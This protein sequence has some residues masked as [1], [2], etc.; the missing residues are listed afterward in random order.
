MLRSFPSTEVSSSPKPAISLWVRCAIAVLTVVAGS[1][2]VRAQDSDRT[3][4][5]VNLSEAAGADAATAKARVLLRTVNGLRPTDTG[6]LTR[7][8][9]SA[10]PEGGPDAPALAEARAG[11]EA[12]EAAFGEFRS[13][14]AKKELDKARRILFAIAPSPATTKLLADLSFHMALIHLRANNMGLAFSE[15]QLQFRLDPTSKIDSV[16][17]PPRIVRAFDQAR[18]ET[19]TKVDATLF[20]S[21]TYDG[22]P[23]FLD[24]APAGFAPLSLPVSAGAH[25]VAIAAPQ[26]KAAARTIDIDP[27]D[28][29]EIRIDLQPRSK[30][31]RALELRFVAKEHAFDEESL[32]AAAA[33]VSQL[34]DSDAVLLIA[35][36]NS[37]AALYIREVDRLS[38]QTEVGPAL[39]HMLGLALPVARPTLL[40]GAIKAAPVA[41]YRNPIGIAALAT[42]V[43]ITIVGLLSLGTSNGGVP[44]RLGKPQWDF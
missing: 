29:Q 5:I 34:I 24:G 26:Y 10:L 14:L 15:F 4:A 41:W 40:D 6:D 44:E 22:A 7:A 25:I 32:R 18:T 42:G 23:I 37:S 16:R 28:T 17:F 9:E 35:G 33:E 11:L 13:R 39:S 2:T 20:I 27:T 31:T 36:K 8:L 12:S 1:N 38:Y 43:S 3:I 30:V 19:P 21:A